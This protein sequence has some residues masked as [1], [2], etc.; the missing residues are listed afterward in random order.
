MG[1]GISSVLVRW[2]ADGADGVAEAGGDN[3]RVCPGLG[4][5]AATSDLGGSLPGLPATL[6]S[7]C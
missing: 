5:A 6:S 7:N 3:C 4:R 1:G 2:T